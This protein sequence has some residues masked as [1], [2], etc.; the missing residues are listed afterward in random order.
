MALARSAR[1]A[2]NGS[3]KAGE[4]TKPPVT[5]AADRWLCHPLRVSTPRKRNEV[6]NL[7]FPGA[8]TAIVLVIFAAAVW[9]W[10]FLHGTARLVV[11]ILWTALEGLIVLGWLASRRDV[12]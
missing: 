8:F 6:F 12:R 4:T 10:I 7:D 2:R 1:D 3:E 11:G 5:P 9:P